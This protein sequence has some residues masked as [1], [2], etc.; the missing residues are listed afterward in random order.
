MQGKRKKK[1]HSRDHAAS[2]TDRRRGVKKMKIIFRLM[3]KIPFLWF[4]ALAKIK[5]LDRA[6][7][8]SFFSAL[9]V[10]C[11]Q[12]TLASLNW[13]F[14]FIPAMN[15]I[16]FRGEI[17]IAPPSNTKDFQLITHRWCDTEKRSC[18]LIFR[19]EKFCAHDKCRPLCKHDIASSTYSETWSHFQLK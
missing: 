8:S 9:K 5:L 7:R 13:V 3:C 17:F 14:L 2:D 6:P 4:I 15:L 1:L 12:P 18:R 19:C 10:A 11:M 16:H